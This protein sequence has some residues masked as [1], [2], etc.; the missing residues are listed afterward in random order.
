MRLH[1][2]ALGVVFCASFGTNPGVFI[3]SEQRHTAVVV[4]VIVLLDVVE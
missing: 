4:I 3:I 2:A 1:G